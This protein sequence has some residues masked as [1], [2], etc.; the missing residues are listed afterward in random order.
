MNRRAGNVGS[1][2]IKKWGKFVIKKE[3]ASLRQPLSG[4][5]GHTKRRSPRGSCSS[6]DGPAGLEIVKGVAS[7][8]P[9]YLKPV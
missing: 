4:G 1:G 8:V 7:A 5:G 2:V 3:L 6:D 9:W